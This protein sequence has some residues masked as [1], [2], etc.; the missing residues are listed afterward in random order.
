MK[1]D[2]ISLMSG[3]WRRGLAAKLLAW[4]RRSARDLPWRRTR[5]LYAIWVSE[6]ML[7]Q[8]QVATVIPYFERF[9]LRFPDVSAL[10]AASEQDVLKMW[11]GLGYYR[12]ARQL[13]AAAKTII[14][15]HE[16]RFPTT[17]DAVRSLAGIGR[18]T[19]GAILS[20]GLDQRLPILEANTIR[21]LSRLTG[22]RGDPRSTAGQQYLWTA[23]EAI[24][25]RR[26]CG[27]FNQALMEL[28]SEICTPRSPQCEGCPVRSLCVAHERRLVHRIPQP[29]KKTK[30]EDV[31]EIA[32]IVRRGQ[33]ILLRQCQPGE[34]WAGLW[35]VPRF[36]APV[37]DSGNLG[38]YIASQTR[39]LVVIRVR[40]VQELAVL[41]HS[42]TRFRIT[43]RCY[44]AMAATS[45]DKTSRSRASGARWVKVK[46]LGDYPLSVTGRRIARLLAAP[47]TSTP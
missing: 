16:G 22:Y 45:R 40:G 43:L 19:A 12:R 1:A 30:Y 2:E 10:A 8:T 34:R 47:P 38:N 20:I 42:V 15:E 44:Q 35:D 3:K 33:Q 24:L 36:V 31:T 27:A 6:I 11:E 4:F 5:D 25:P 29:A 37:E 46:E 39:R 18:Y 7:Q 32:V 14:R 28:G 23:A 26:E 21:V 9:L 13:H 17:I 41:K